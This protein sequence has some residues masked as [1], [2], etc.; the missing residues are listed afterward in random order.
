MSAQ[1]AVKGDWL[2]QWDPEDEKSW[3]KSLAWN[4]LIVTTVS[5]TLCFAA[6]FL[7]SALVPKLTALGF[8]IDTSGLYW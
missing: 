7:P 6:W 1:Q 2:Q 4:T 5:L 8:G 3:D